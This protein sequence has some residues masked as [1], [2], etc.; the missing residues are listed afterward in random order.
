MI[1]ELD[2][3]SVY[4]Q[5]HARALAQ[6]WDLRLQEF[7]KYDGKPYGI[8]YVSKIPLVA[9]LYAGAMPFEGKWIRVII[10][11]RVSPKNKVH[12]GFD[13]KLT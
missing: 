10:M 5:L 11:V 13:E 9:E 6:T 4:G 12:G 1:P 8:I 2:I 3:T 7:L